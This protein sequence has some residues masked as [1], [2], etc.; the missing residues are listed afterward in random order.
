ASSLALSI[1]LP[2]NALAA[3]SD[4]LRLEARFVRKNEG[5]IT[6]TST[7][8]GSSS[9]RRLSEIAT[10]AAFTAVYDVMVGG[11]TCPASEAVLT[12]RPWPCFLSIGTKVRQP[13]AT[14]SRLMSVMRRQSSSV[15]IS[16]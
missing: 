7:P 3:G 11:C 13:R 8:N 10:T 6:E 2:A 1:S 9:Q 14:P 4:E 12:T 15:S 16:I 5:Q